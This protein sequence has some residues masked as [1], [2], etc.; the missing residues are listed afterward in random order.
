MPWELPDWPQFGYNRIAQK[1]KQFLLEV[2]NACAFLKNRGDQEYSRL[3]V[4]SDLDFSHLFK[5]L[6][7]SQFKIAK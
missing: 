3:V 2:D 7:N 6:Q 4:T 5:L 1:E